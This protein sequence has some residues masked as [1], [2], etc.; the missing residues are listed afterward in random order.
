MKHLIIILFLTLANLT[1]GAQAPSVAPSS[2]F[3]KLTATEAVELTLEADFTTFVSQKKTNNYLPGILRTKDGKSYSVEI[4]PRGRYRRKV[5]QIPPIK[6]RFNE[7]D[8]QAENLDSLNEIK[9]AL[10]SVHSEQGNELI[11]KEYL[12]YRMF[13]KVSNVY[14]RARLVKLTLIDANEK[15][16]GKKKLYAIFI[17]DEEEVARRLKGVPDETYGIKMENLEQQQAALVVMFEYL[18]GNT[19]WDL[20]MHRNV[21]M[22]KDNDT[23]KLLVLPYDFDFSGLVSAPYASPSSESGVK[24]VRDRYLMSAGID[25][26]ALKSATNLLK[27]NEKEFYKICRSKFLSSE[28]S[29]GMV[30]FLESFYKNMEGKDVAPTVMMEKK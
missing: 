30:T 8:L 22:L 28:S 10:P 26:E 1:L 11:V 27:T 4:R 9:I 7:K 29:L 6:I 12:A 24:T 3:E 5:S 13:E 21:E 23:E 16:S 19:D 14:F 20:S 25:A 2:I 17:E 18:I 15:A